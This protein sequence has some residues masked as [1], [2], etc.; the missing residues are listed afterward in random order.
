M[1]EYSNQMLFRRQ[2]ASLVVSIPFNLV[3]EIG[4]VPGD[5]ALFQR[6]P[7]GLKLRLIRYSPLAE[8]SNEQAAT[9]AA[10]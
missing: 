8:R 2:G 1:T 3:R 7:D 10:E 9:E 6:V 4:L 5:A